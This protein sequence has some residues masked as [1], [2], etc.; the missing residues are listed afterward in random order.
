MLKKYSPLIMS[1]LLGI[2]LLALPGVSASAATIP[3]IQQIV[4]GEMNAG[5]GLKQDVAQ[6]KGQKGANNKRADRRWNR[7]RDGN[8]CRTRN[9]N[10][11]HFYNGYYYASPWWLISVPLIIG[12][13]LA[14]GDG[15]W[16]DD[17]YS[18]CQDRYRSYNRRHNTWVSRG[19]R[20]YQCRSPY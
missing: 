12:G 11:R 3:V 7:K 16:S 8:R 13:S 17:H 6:K 15:D 14:L 4:P 19:G 9:G 10:C 18:W 1:S 5:T 2:G 20:V